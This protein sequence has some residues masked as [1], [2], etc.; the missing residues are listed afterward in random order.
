MVSRPRYRWFVLKWKKLQKKLKLTPWGGVLYI[1]NIAGTLLFPASSF[2]YATTLLVTIPLPL[3]KCSTSVASQPILMF[4]SS[5]IS[6]VPFF[7]FVKSPA[8][9]LFRFWGTVII[10]PLFLSRL[11]YIGLTKF[12]KHLFSKWNRKVDIFPNFLLITI[13]QK[14]LKGRILK[15][16]NSSGVI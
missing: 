4:V 12:K 2:V 6:A 11:H 8:L 15:I 3:K 16:E 9:S 13:F 5:N 1:V 14:N 7:S 10:R